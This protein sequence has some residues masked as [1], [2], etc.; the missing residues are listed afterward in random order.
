MSFSQSKSFNIT[1]KLLSQDNKMPLEAATVYLERTK[2]SS[3]VTYTISDKLGVFEI[4][5]NTYDEKLNLYISYVG[6]N[7]NLP[8][9]SISNISQL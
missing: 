6:Y 9:T 2:D 5:D 7:I 1:G 8:F 3:L 4:S